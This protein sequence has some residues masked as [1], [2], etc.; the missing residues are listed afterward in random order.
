M[1]CQPPQPSTLVSQMSL[2]LSV[3]REFLSVDFYAFALDQSPKVSL[4]FSR[5]WIQRSRPQTTFPKMH[6][7]VDGVLGQWFIIN[8]QTVQ[9]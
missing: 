5:S 3:S 6:F 2:I 8:D 4:T 1:S 9:Q 7:S